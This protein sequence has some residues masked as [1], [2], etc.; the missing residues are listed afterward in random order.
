MEY[1]PGTPA[2]RESM[3][4]AI[5]MDTFSDL[6]SAV[7]KEV[8]LKRPLDITKG[9]S[10]IELVVQMKSL[11]TKNRVY[12]VMFRGAGSY[13]HFIPAVV[14]N[15]SARGE[16]LTAYTP[17]QAELSQ[18]ILQAIFEYQT[19]ICEITGLDVSNAS[20]YDGATAAGE[21]AIMV[22][23]RKR[24][25][26]LVSDAVNPQIIETIRTY[27]APA[28]LIVESIA[29]KNG[30]TDLT[31]LSEK[32]NDRTAGV[33]IAQPNYYGVLEDMEEASHIVHAAG[34]KLIAGV[35]PISLGI[36]K[37]PGEYGADIAVGDGQ[38]L[39][40]PMSFGG[41]G[42]GFMA[43]PK[44]NMRR[45]PG[46]I[47][48]ETKDHSNR[49]AYVLTL[50]AREQHIRREKASSNICS[51]QAW[52]ALRSAIYMSAVGKVGFAT[53]A[54]HCYA[55]AH[56]LADRL[57]EIGFKRI[58]DKE[59]F[60]EFVTELPTSAEKLQNGLDQA[61]MLSGLPMNNNKMLWCATE[62][63]GKAEIDRLINAISEICV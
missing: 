25:R 18:G 57:F 37:S 40:I 42:F 16:F 27:A 9:I 45:L 48:G 5:E 50:Q 59:F 49:R 43:V 35:N 31:D 8:L 62:L 29:I 63:T 13:K 55:N 10:E 19:M 58:Y 24:E 17:Y 6:Y 21:A 11:A 51:N 38:P 36:L 46:R 30:A 56:Y 14:D 33:Y 60:H 41:P 39:G 12:P 47:V 53:V 2:E 61:G 28:G 22:K 20:V 52:C 7:P 4:R 44:E 34:A 54:Q 32:L 26:I 23:D 1:I 3:L 15:L